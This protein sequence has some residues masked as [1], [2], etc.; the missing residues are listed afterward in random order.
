MVRTECI[1]IPKPRKRKIQFRKVRPAKKKS[2][3]PSSSC[4]R[5]SN[6]ANVVSLAKISCAWSTNTYYLVVVASIIS[7]SCV[8]SKPINLKVLIKTKTLGVESRRSCSNSE[9]LYQEIDFQTALM[10]YQPCF[11]R[12]QISAPASLSYRRL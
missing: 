12:S 6:F 10:Q 9:L 11:I 8:F 2:S 4:I 5:P 1:F 7:E 3:L